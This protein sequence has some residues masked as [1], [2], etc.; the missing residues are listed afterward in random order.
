ML[1]RETIMD[2]RAP[3]RKAFTLIELLTVIAVLAVLMALLFP[4]LRGALA[5]ARR[6][7]C[8]NHLRQ[9]AMAWDMYLD[10]NSQRFLQGNRVNHDFAGWQGIGGY[11]LSR[12]LNPYMGGLPKEVKQREMTKG[13]YCSA[14]GGGVMG[15][16]PQT[17][18]YDYFGNSYQT[19]FFLI[20]PN[21]TFDFR[22]EYKELYQNINNRL[23]NLSLNDVS[24]SARLVLAGD[25]NWKCQ[26]EVAYRPG[27]SW[28]RRDQYYNLAF[29]DGHVDFIQ[30]HKDEL[31]TPVYRI[32]PFK[33][34]DK[35]IP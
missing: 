32:M 3:E 11:A 5:L 25:N 31:T 8:Q 16:A 26:W 35:L 33:D 21:Q 6:A 13:L 27:V 15:V 2:L 34:L 30:V 23:V 19:N 7:V 28:H 29:M 20:G 22:E 4:V 10:D 24:D 9:I 1:N 14:D 18:A 17:K 12:P